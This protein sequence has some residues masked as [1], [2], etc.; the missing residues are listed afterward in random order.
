M[1]RVELKQTYFFL[2]IPLLIILFMV[3]IARYSGILYQGEVESNRLI[4]IS[5]LILAS[6]FSLGVPVFYRTLFVTKIKNR[7][8]I[9][10]EEFLKFEKTLILIALI[11]PYFVIAALLLNLPKFFSTA[12]VLIAIYAVYYYYPS[13]KRIKF[14][15]RIFR[16][17]E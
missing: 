8:S 4:S 5:V 1:I 14:E 15:K 11:S 17:K 13:E 6:L 3:F 16:I 10:T 2:I 9:S 12:V 7:K